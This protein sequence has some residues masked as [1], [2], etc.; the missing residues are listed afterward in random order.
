MELERDEML[1]EIFVYPTVT[2]VHFTDENWTSKT[3]YCIRCGWFVKYFLLQIPQEDPKCKKV[4]FL[5]KR[6]NYTFASI[7]GRYLLY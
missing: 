6:K 7:H 4:C 3:V 1:P 5:S 2:V